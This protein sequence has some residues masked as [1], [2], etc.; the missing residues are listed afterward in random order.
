M[1]A[2]IAGDERGCRGNAAR[3]AV[4]LALLDAFGRHFREPIATVTRLLAPE[5]YEPRRHVRYSGA[6][7]SAQGCKP[8]LAGVEVL[9]LRVSSAQDQG[10]HRR[11]GRCRSRRR[12]AAACGPAR[13]PARRCQRGVDGGRR[14][15][16]HRRAEAV[17]H[18]RGRAAGAACGARGAG[19]RAAG[20]G[21]ADHA[22][23]IAVQ[24]DRC[25]AGGIGGELRP[26]QSPALQVRRVHP[27]AA[28]GTIRAAP[29]AGLPARLPG[30]RDGDPIRGGAALRQQR[31]RAALP[32]RLL[33]SPPGARG[34]GD[35]DI[36]FG[37]G[38][39]APALAGPG[40]GITIDPAALERTAV[41]KEVL[42]G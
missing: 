12:G 10:R 36:T 17:R 39:W 8:R 9:V 18:Q 27:I 26:V 32:R 23:R 14:V 13:G 35:E 15:P 25:R 20:N 2:P 19:G 3:C 7:T 4:E 16:A 37:W 24:H 11:A 1:P 42:L 5:L 6:I 21:R 33:R 28:A 40:L 31:R 41:R 29:W 22:R 38:G 30:R 34:A